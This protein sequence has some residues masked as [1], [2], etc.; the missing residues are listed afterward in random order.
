MNP[1]YENAYFLVICEMHC[2]KY[3]R[4]CSNN[5]TI[6]KY[7]DDLSFPTVFVLH[8]CLLTEPSYDIKTH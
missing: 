6:E 2:V 7:P 8:K 3:V 1:A 5:E 4:K